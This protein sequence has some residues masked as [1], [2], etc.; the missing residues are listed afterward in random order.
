MKHDNWLFF[1][2]FKINSMIEK[3]AEFFQSNLI[4][5]SLFIITPWF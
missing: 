2:V 4:V 1:H 5:D 3:L